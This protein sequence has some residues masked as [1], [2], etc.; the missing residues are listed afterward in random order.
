MK[1]IRIPM[2]NIQK[3][4]FNNSFF[5]IGSCFSENIAKN[6][7]S[8]G[9][10]TFSNPFG[11][12]YKPN[13]IYQQLLHITTKDK[14]SYEDLSFYNGKYFLF[15]HSA[16]NDCDNPDTVL[17]SANNQLNQAK[18]F[19]SQADVFLITL[20][21]AVIYETY[22]SVCPT[23]AN[24][25]KIIT[26]NCHRVPQNKMNRR[27]L[28]HSE[29]C[30]Y[31]KQ[32]VEIIKNVKNNAD[33]IITISP[34]KHY[35]GEP[36]LDSTSKSRLKSALDEVT[37]K[38]SDN[39]VFYFPSYEIFR[40]ELCD[41]KWY[42]NDGTH[43]NKKAV[44]FIMKNFISSS[45]T[46]QTQSVMKEISSIKKLLHHR[47]TA[48]ESNAN[49]EL[50][51]KITMQLQKIQTANTSTLRFETACKLAR[52]FYNHEQTDKLIDELFSEN[53]FFFDSNEKNL[54]LELLA[55]FRK[56]HNFQSLPVRLFSDKRLS[57]MLISFLTKN[58]V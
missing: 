40:D 44:S 50:L 37:E 11:V 34:A 22:Q 43:P 47:P 56:E 15:C 32:T 46:K 57:S 7:A 35:P 49:F 13:T 14:Y 12:V 18:N 58:D 36:L 6:L 3:Y 2:Q 16:A 19:F 52:N 54:I 31:I 51:K 9:V 45:F 5:S 42:K 23:T 41:R 53:N 24:E 38:Y 25:E 48:P 28:T 39:N 10:K 26:A 1:R 27:L 29:C 20:G 21:S 4:S 30:E 55:F 33:I 17:N 8:L